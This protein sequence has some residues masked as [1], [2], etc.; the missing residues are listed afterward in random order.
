MEEESHGLPGLGDTEAEVHRHRQHIV[1]EER[2]IMH[3]VHGRADNS[4]DA[5]EPPELSAARLVGWR[6]SAHP[7]ARARS[8]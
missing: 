4:A 5:S 1:S 8:W 2:L 6:R 3:R 7:R